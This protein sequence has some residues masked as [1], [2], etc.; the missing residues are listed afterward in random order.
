VEEQ[1]GS[2]CNWRGRGLEA[3]CQTLSSAGASVIVADIRPDIAEKVALDIQASGKEAMA[4][5]LDVSNESKQPL[6]KGGCQ[7]GHLDVLMRE[8]MS[9][10]IEEL[11]IQDWDRISPSTCVPSSCQSSPYQ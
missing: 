2:A 3:V 8:R 10:S 4:L 11:P 9:R 1:G 6:S 7:Y 5:P